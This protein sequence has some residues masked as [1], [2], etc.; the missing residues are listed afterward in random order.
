MRVQAEVLAA[1]DKQITEWG[2]EHNE[3]G[4]RADAY[5]Y[6][7][8]VKPDGCAYYI[9]PA[10]SWLVGEKSKVVVRWQREGFIPF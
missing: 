5:R 10:P 3:R 2:I 1:A 9:P 8:E 6:C 4:E 7:V